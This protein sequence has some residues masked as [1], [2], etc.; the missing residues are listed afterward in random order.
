MTCV[1]RELSGRR[2]LQEF[3]R[4]FEILD[5]MCGKMRHVFWVIECKRLNMSIWQ[6]AAVAIAD[7]MTEQ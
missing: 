7:A 4:I 3:W 2:P 5:E 6:G 1:V